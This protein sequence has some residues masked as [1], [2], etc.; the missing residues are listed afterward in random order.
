MV[1]VKS[2]LGNIRNLNEDYA[3][4]YEEDK[5]SIYVVAD[6]MGGHNAGEIASKIATESIIRYIKENIENNLLKKTLKDAIEYANEKVYSL[7]YKSEN[8]T[9]MGTTV[10]ACLITNMGIQIGNVGDSSCFVV[11]DNRVY[12]LTKDH[13]LVQELLDTGS[14]SKEQ[15]INH[16]QKNVIT[17]AIGTGKEVEIDIYNL[18]KEDYDYILLCTDGLTNDIDLEKELL[19]LINTNNIQKVCDELVDRAKKNGGRDN[20]TVMLLGRGV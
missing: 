5:V 2:D 16:P 18:N 12:K 19:E 3:E 9:G 17:R 8:Y 15:A 7:A 14:I 10:V 4:F 6:G 11:N 13:S 1:G 20:I